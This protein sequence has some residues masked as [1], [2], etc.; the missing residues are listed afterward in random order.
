MHAAVETGFLDALD[1]EQERAVQTVVDFMANIKANAKKIFKEVRVNIEL[2]NGHS[3]FG[4][5]DWF[6]IQKNKPNGT[7]TEAVLADWKFGRLPVPHAEKNL[8]A[9]AYAVGA[10]QKFPEVDQITVFFVMPR[11]GDV[12][13]ATLVRAKLD[14]YVKEL[15]DLFDL[16]T[17]PDPRRTPCKACEYCAKFDGCPA[18]AKTITQVGLSQTGGLVAPSNTDPASMTVVELD[19]FGLPFARLVEAWAK[20]VKKRAMDLLLDGEEMKHH[21]VGERAAI[22]KL[23]GD[24]SKSV[25]LAMSL[26]IP[27]DE[28]LQCCSLSISQLKKKAKKNGVEETLIA[29]LIAGGLLEAE[30]PKTNY[31]KRK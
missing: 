6:S 25:D 8:Q 28:I 4:T 24:T 12:S 9:L 23:Q 22:Q 10:F 20:S 17:A 21:V 14:S 19:E 5:A 26:G 29:A 30:N 16:I 27:K 7:Q 18:I 3:T 2:G 1:P 13:S 15:T 11:Q 31:L